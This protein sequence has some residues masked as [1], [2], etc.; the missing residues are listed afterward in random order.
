MYRHI[1]ISMPL[2]RVPGARI[3]ARALARALGVRALARAKTDRDKQ[4]QNRSDINRQLFISNYIWYNRV[5]QRKNAKSQSHSVVQ[6]PPQNSLSP[7]LLVLHRR[8]NALLAL[9]EG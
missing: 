3:G 6:V 8:P 1:N 4:H 5:K 9:L 2:A 7:L